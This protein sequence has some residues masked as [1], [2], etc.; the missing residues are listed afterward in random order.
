MWR[1]EQEKQDRY[2]MLIITLLFANSMLFAN[3][4]TDIVMK[5]LIITLLFAILNV[6]IIKETL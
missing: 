6:Y 2:K 1:L 4:I 3:S 5:M